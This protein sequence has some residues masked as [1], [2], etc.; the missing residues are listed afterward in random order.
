MA[1]GIN[2]Y[3]LQQ[4]TGAGPFTNQMANQPI[5]AFP[6]PRQAPAPRQGMGGRAM[7]ILGSI[8]NFIQD[9]PALMNRLAIGF[10][11]MTLNPNAA[12][13]NA[14]Q[15]QLEAQQQLD[16]L[17]DQANKTAEYLRRMGYTTEADIVEKNPTMAQDV[18]KAVIGKTIGTSGIKTSQVYT[19]PSSGQQYVVETNP[20]TG[21]IARRDVEGATGLTPRQEQEMETQTALTLADRESAQAAGQRYYG[22]AESLN[23]QMTNLRRAYT[24][25]AAG[26]G[27]GLIRNLLPAFDATTSQL[28]QAANSLGIDVINS[29]TF[30]ALSATELQL[31]L[32]TAIDMSLGPEELQKQITAKLAAQEKLYNELL[33]SAQLLSSGNTGYSTFIQRQEFIPVTPPAGVPLSDWYGMDAN[34]K[35]QA[36]E[37][38]GGNQ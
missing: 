18:F 11:G 34:Q 12:I 23:T 37:L 17:R 38:F 15:R 9:N 3:A 27:S 1:N 5:P 16:L 28:R 32:S 21:Q 8:G 14:N 10:Q 13:I 29:A 19:D 24:A 20:N 6:P 30:G 35:R 7:G 26:G 31:A 22:Q 36:I 33:R 2:P 25:S 4:A